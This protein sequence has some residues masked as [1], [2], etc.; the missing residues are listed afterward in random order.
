[1]LVDYHS[2]R[3]YVVEGD[4]LVPVVWRGDLDPFDENSRGA[5]LQ[6]RRGDH[7]PRRRDGRVGPARQRARLRVR[8]D[9]PRHGRRGRVDHRRPAALRH[10]GHRR[11]RHLQAR[12]R[13]RSTRTTSASSRCSAA[14]PPSRSRTPAST[15]PSGSRRSGPRPRSRSRTRCSTSAAASRSPS[16]WT[17]CSS[18][19]STWPPGSSTSL[20]PPSGSR[21]APAR[22]SSCARS[23]L[24]PPRR[25][26]AR[27]D[28]RAGRAGARAPRGR[29][30]VP[31]RRRPVP[32]GPDAPSCPAAGSRS[33][34]SGSTAT[35][36]AASSFATPATTT[37][38]DER[39]MRLLAGVAHQ[40]KLAVANAQSY[41]SLEQTFLSTV[42]A[43]ANALEANDEY[44]SSHA[45]WI[46]DMALHVGGELGMDA[47][48]LKRLELGALFHDIGKIGI[49]EAILAKPGP[50][51]DEEW[52][53]VR[54]H[55][56]LGARILAPDRAAGAGLR[57]RPPLPR[58]LGRQRLPERPRRRGDPARV[59]RHPRLR[60]LPRH[61]DRPAVS[62]A[63]PG[64]GSSA[65]GSAR[66]PARSSTRRSSRSSSPWTPRR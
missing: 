32:P 8:R 60:R 52:K 27:V 45:R 2:C 25:G 33:R 55:P 13:R 17:R 3:L 43:L 47:K 11:R 4:T 19:R 21:I 41:E 34:R 48:A 53:L 30:A 58:A 9:H 39:S 42:E 22:T 29:R 31:A 36:S 7:G 37:S 44:T 64:R 51:S 18:G 62:P 12:R 66:P 54:L 38:F 49:P 23:R 5:L 65:G 24:R 28:H 50:L 16:R 63:A 56:E 14:M 26:A 10:A 1:M 15:R 6:D 35:A 46:T 61:D 57:D 40:V 59:A 20:G